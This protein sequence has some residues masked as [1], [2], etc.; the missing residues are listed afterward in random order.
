MS[1]DLERM[2]GVTE[3]LTLARDDGRRREKRK[4]SIGIFMA[5]ESD[6]LGNRGG[7]EGRG[8]GGEWW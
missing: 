8:G 3:I 1:P 4:R 5:R 2:V 6:Q 7:G